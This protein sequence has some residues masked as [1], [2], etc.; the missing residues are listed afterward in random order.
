ML[1]FLVK[2]KLA[3]MFSAPILVLFFAPAFVFVWPWPSS[4]TFILTKTRTSDQGR[5]GRG[6]EAEKKAKA[7][8]AIN[9]QITASITPP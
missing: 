5:E 2:L 1:N 6:A 7:V 3:N 9:Y 4:K 8:G